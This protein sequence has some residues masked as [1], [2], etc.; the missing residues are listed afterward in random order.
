LELLAAG[1]QE[2]DQDALRLRSSGRA[3][4]TPYLASYHHRPDGLFRSPVRG[5]QAGTVQEG[6]ESVALPQKMI[7]QAA[8][9]R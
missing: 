1:L 7:G 3:I 8:I 5:L 6:E 4:S 2:A 9:P